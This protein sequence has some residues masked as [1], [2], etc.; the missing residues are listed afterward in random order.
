MSKAIEK[1]IISILIAVLTCISLSSA[2]VVRY[3]DSLDQKIENQMLD[4][5]V[6][7]TE[8]RKLQEKYNYTLDENQN[9]TGYTNFL[10]SQNEV[11][12]DEEKN[13]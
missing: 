10:E 6:Y 7:K 4:I 11:L 3:I 12:M 9:F 13:K 5:I 2:V 8:L 1:I